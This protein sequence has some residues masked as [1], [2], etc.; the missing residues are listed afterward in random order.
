MNNQSVVLAKTFIL[1]CILSFLS[2]GPAVTFTEPQPAGVRNLADIPNRLV[3][4]Y[5]SLSDSSTLA[6]SRQNIIRHYTTLVKADK[7]HL[8]SNFVLQNDTLRDL[9]TG[10]KWKVKLLGDTILHMLPIS[11]TLFSI[12]A[13]GI[14]KKYKGYYF[15]NTAQKGNNW[16]VKKISL[17]RGKLILGTITSQQ[18][19]DVL[20]TITESTQDSVP[21]TF[22]LTKKQFKQFVKQDGFSDTETFIRVK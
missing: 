3:G 16:E 14:L 11:D 1:L 9:T 6:I 8:D 10:E 15:I 4:K 19:I 21:Y 7:N 18:D 12:N 22:T 13:Y 5:L 2:C 20:K 17:S